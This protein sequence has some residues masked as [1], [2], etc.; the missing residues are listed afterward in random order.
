MRPDRT[1]ILKSFP[2]P[3]LFIIGEFDNAIPLQSSLQQCYLPAISHVYILKKSGHMSML[4]ETEKANTI[5][6]DFLRSIN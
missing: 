3:I 6:L 5:L 4:E 1:H 2:K